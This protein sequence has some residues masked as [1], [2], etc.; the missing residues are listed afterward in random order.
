MSLEDALELIAKPNTVR[1]NQVEEI[2]YIPNYNRSAS[3][4]HETLPGY[5]IYL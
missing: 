3:Q 4:S 1:H 5:D 2:A